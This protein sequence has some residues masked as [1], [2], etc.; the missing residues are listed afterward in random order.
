MSKDNQELN[1]LLAS[2]D[3]DVKR[4][5]NRML[6]AAQG[7]YPADES[8]EMDTRELGSLV[9]WTTGDNKRFIPASNTSPRLVP[10]VYEIQHSPQVGIF[11]EKIPVKTEGLLRF[12]Q[13]NS[14]RVVTGGGVK[15]HPVRV[16]PMRRE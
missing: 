7:G 9:Q 11:F 12:P 2:S 14:D 15:P 3:S 5:R 13:T 6:K 16:V 4:L 10:G 8:P 1:E